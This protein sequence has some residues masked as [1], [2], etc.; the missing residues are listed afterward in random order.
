MLPVI[1]GNSQLFSEYVREQHLEI[2]KFSDHDL[3]EA[4]PRMRR[5]PL[6]GEAKGT[7]PSG[8][9]LKT[10]LRNDTKLVTET[11]NDI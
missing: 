5:G 3:V 9:C 1:V 4:K 11:N 10:S 7:D 2:K 6:E 8:S